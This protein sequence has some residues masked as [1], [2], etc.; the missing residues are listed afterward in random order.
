MAHCPLCG[1]ITDP[2]ILAYANTLTDATQRQLRTVAP[3]WLPALG[4]CPQCALDAV[5]VLGATRSDAP[6]NTLTDPPTTFPYYHPDEETV[7]GQTAR[8]PDYATFGAQGVTIAF[9]DSG[10]YPHP[11]L[12]AGR[13]RTPCPRGEHDACCTA[14]VV[15]GAADAAGALCDLRGDRVQEG[16]DADSLWETDWLSWHGEMTTVIAAGNGWLSG[17]RLRGYAPRAGV[18]PIAVGRGDGR[19]PEA[20]I[21]AGFQ[22][23]LQD[24]NWARYNVRVVN[25]SVGGD[26]PDYWTDNAVCLAAEELS[27]RGVLICAAA[28]NSGA[29]R[30]LAPAQAPSVLTVGGYD[31]ANRRWSPHLPEE[32]ARLSLYHHNFGHVYAADGPLQKPEILAVGRYVASPILPPSP[33]LRETH[34]IAALRQVLTGDDPAHL[35]R[36]LAHWHRVMHVE[37]E[38]LALG[39]LLEQRRAHR[40]MDAALPEIWQALRKR[41]NAH[42][43]VHAYYQHADGTSVAVAQVAAVAAQMFQANPRLNGEQVKALLLATA[44][45]I[46]HFPTT[47]QGRG[48]L[49]PVAA[50]TA[51]LRAPG[52]I[53]AG[54]PVS[55][56][57][58]HARQLRKWNFQG[59]LTRQSATVPRAFGDHVAS[60]SEYAYLGHYAPGAS[61]VSVLA[62]FNGWTPALQPLERTPEGWWHTAVQLPP[63]LYPYRFWVVDRPHPDGHWVSDPEN[64]RRIESGYAAPHALLVID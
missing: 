12:L 7:L 32:V 34:A 17:G 56:T 5:R 54:M 48:V 26:H 1:A 23:L 33:V 49:Q 31:D 3:G 10:F 35:E 41:M 15:A 21:L 63:G 62:A 64:P 60:P 44:R 47:L 8:L 36:L 18:L 11:D 58:V 24:D 29:E 40:E 2:R 51:A 9:L 22:W 16:L 37:E 42:K 59:T 6:L 61:A 25:V 39:R 46:G 19:I 45:P 27:R 55:G 52:G 53:L 13:R 14:H 38:K 20:D 30:L 43:W 4:L 50:V 57:V 28:G